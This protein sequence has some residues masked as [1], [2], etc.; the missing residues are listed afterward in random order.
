MLFA[1]TVQ[2]AHCCLSF[3]DVLWP[4]FS[5]WDLYRTI[6]FYQQNHAHI[7]VREQVRGLFLIS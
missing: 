5:A 1:V 7:K 2:S 3:V 4:E 6:L